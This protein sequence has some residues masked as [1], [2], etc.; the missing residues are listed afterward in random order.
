MIGK[1][2]GT[3]ESIRDQLEFIKA[4]EIPEKDK[5]QMRIDLFNNYTSFKLAQ[6]YLGLVIELTNVL[7]LMILPFRLPSTD[8]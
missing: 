4:L 2:F 5:I 3:R 1:I 8:F 6:R 7:K